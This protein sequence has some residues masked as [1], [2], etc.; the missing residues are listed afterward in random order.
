MIKIELNENW[1][2]RNSGNEEG[3]IPATIPGC[4]HTDLLAA[5]R[6]PDPWY[7]DNEKDIHWVSHED[8]IY[9]TRFEVTADVL[10]RKHVVLRFDGL[11]TLCTVE[12]NGTIVLEADNMHRTWEVD[13]KTHLREGENELRLAFVSP[14][15]YMKARDAEK[16]LWGWNVFH[17]DFWG[18]SYVRKMACAFGWDWGLMAPTA[19]VWRPARSIA[20]DNRIS[21][22]YLSQRRE[23][24]KVH[25]NFKA[26]IEGEGKIRFRLL[27]DSKVVGEAHAENGIGEIVVSKPKLWWPNGMGEQPLYELV[28]ELL[29]E[30]G[31]VI[32]SDT[33]HIGLRTCELVREADEFGESFKFRV[34]GRDVF[35]KGGN[36]IPCDVFPSNISDA[37]Y[38]HL[39]QS[40][41]DSHMNMIRVWGGGIYEDDRFYHLC[42]EL[43]ILVWQD[44][45]FACSTYPSFDDIFMEN[46]RKEAI[47]NVRR[48]RHHPCL[49]LWCGNNELEQGL[50][51]WNA[52]D[53]TDR[54]MPPKDY[55]ALFDELLPEVV[56]K[57]D[58]S[59][60]YWPSSGHTPGDG[61]HNCWDDTAGDAHSW[62][63]WFGGQPIEAQRD[64]K[65]RFMSEFGFQSYPELRTVKAFT[66]PDDRNMINWIMDY[67]QRSDSG[68]QKILKYAIDWFKEADGFENSLIVSQMIQAL[69]VQYAGEHARRIQGRMDG[70]LYWQINDLWPGA[71]WSSI[72]V[73]GRWK[74]LHYF[75]KRFF[76][77]VLVSLLE[78]HGAGTVDVHVSNHRPES[79]SGTIRWFI[80]D[81]SGTVLRE[82][83]L[84]AS[85]PSQ[86]NKCMTTLSCMQ[87]R[88]DGG[89]ERLPL[90]IR[91]HD[92]IPMAGDRDIL[93]WAILEENG[94]EVS[95]NLSWFSKPKYWKLKSPEIRVTVSMAEEKPVIELETS[96][97]AP[98]TQLAL[99]DRDVRFSD[100]YLHLLPGLPSRITV[101]STFPEALENLEE[102]LIVKPFID[103]FPNI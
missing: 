35:M 24:A 32:D 81:A 8:W 101:E 102:Q 71:T 29:D 7:R 86:A 96:H 25:L 95:R 62:S 15:P 12:V 53:W 33:K 68:N 103:L 19:G 16:R 36:W 64:W 75:A 100:N 6:I 74:A 45:M 13:V 46:V 52:D 97:A 63:V 94:T 98:W 30:D 77:P 99:P 20:Y 28:T 80:T 23:E 10:E 67:H 85:V 48:I 78:D 5:G 89:T 88:K 51:D 42:D 1:V 73:Y 66:A 56:A 92:N 27:F 82:G 65:F 40:C 31:K 79:F 87:Y 60:P 49:A 61:R 34:N 2:L 14:I 54:A 72:D 93:V 22:V 38:R 3:P 44:F 39:L 37:T 76:A 17:E 43:G 21:E 84:E 58:P 50:V 59:T 55:L 4:V 9:E 26:K 41:T 83:N 18:K 69:C 70:L 47:D 91:N 11:D 90:E 57:E